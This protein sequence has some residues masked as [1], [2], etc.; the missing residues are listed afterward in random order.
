MKTPNSR[1]TITE[2][3]T[4]T[5]SEII[6]QVKKLVREGNAR[7][8]MIENKDGK[9][10]FQSQLTVGLA[11]TVALAVISPLLTAIGTFALFMKD[12]KIIVERYPDEENKDE[13]EIEAEFIEIKD[14]E[15]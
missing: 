1:K 13:N 4:G 11:G 14:E 12:M 7:R 3:V 9:V 2:E 5:V 8:V 15:E 6:A 10:V